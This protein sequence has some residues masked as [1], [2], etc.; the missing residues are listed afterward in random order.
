MTMARSRRSPVTVPAVSTVPGAGARDGGARGA[1]VRPG[2][3]TRT[4][5][6]GLE[7][8]SAEELRVLLHRARAYTGGPDSVLEPEAS[9]PLRGRFVATLFFEDSTRTRLSF[10]VAA[11]RLGAQ[12]IDLAVASSS[13][14]KGETITD[15]A[16]NVNAMGVD[17]MVVRHRA[18]GAAVIVDRAVGALADP[19]R[20][21][22]PACTVVNAGDGRHEHPTQGL[23][24]AYT[25]AEAHQRLE[26][27]DLSGLRVAIVGDVISSRVARSDIAALTA[28]GAEVVCVGPPALVPPAIASLG[29]AVAH[30]LDAV[31]PGVDAV[32]VLRIQFERHDDGE[33]RRPEGGGGAG[34]TGEARRTAASAREFREC[35]GLSEARAAR[36]RPGA[37]VMHPGPINR[38]LEMDAAVAD[39]PRSAVLRQVG[40]GV[41]IRMAVLELCIGARG[42]GA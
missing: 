8:L 2:G 26:T 35:F 1:G 25:I 31:L 28:L 32:Q 16:T 5:L 7:G 29:C 11:Q 22:G 3:W 6:L 33:A 40:H 24:D 13:V 9:A 21:R 19:A 39:G 15:T 27:F 18:S 36:M 20:R 12:V 37:I 14:N 17:A 10:A 41:A 38:G 34:G 30:D 42:P 23:L 4:S